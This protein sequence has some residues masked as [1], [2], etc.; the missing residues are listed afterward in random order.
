[1]PSWSK[2]QNIGARDATQTRVELMARSVL[3]INLVVL[4]QCCSWSQCEWTSML[5][6]GLTGKQLGF[7]E[8]F[9]H[10]IRQRAVKRKKRSETFFKSSFSFG[11]DLAFD[12]RNHQECMRTNELAWDLC[13]L[14]KMENAALFGGKN[15]R[16]NTNTFVLPL[17]DTKNRSSSWWEKCEECFFQRKRKVDGRG[18]G[19]GRGREI[20][21]EALLG[22]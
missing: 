3:S 11:L 6:L 4:L 5:N 12:S 10:G 1:M 18:K 15:K 21:G 9:G 22:S 16:A 13:E 8:K 7:L 2:S 14:C 17:R 20:G 19:R